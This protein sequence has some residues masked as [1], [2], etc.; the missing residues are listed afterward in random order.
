MKTKNLLLLAIIIAFI[1]GCSKNN[2]KQRAD[3]KIENKIVQ[4][5][6]E[7]KNQ[8]IGKIKLYK[9]KSVEIPKEK[10]M[11]P[12]F[13]WDE[14]GT[15]VSSND[16]K[17]KVQFLNFW[18][19]WC[20]PCKK[21]MPDLSEIAIEYKEKP[22]IMIGLNVFQQAGAPKVE[23]FLKSNPVSYIIVDGNQELV[24]AFKKSTGN[25]MSAVPTSFVVDKNGKIV[26]TIVGMRSKADFKKI[27]EKY[28]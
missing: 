17:G 10:N 15:E 3:E 23:D 11:I 8:E 28:L 27:I 26:E 13:K 16:H 24:E 19:T 12:N 4:T 22:F 9:L 7:K 18:A 21:E 5:N 6:Q 2:E 25:D 20:G 14:N 1:S